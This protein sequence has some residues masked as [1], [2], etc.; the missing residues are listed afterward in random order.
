M[1]SNTLDEDE[2]TH[3][4]LLTGCFLLMFFAVCG[5]LRE[6]ELEYAAKMRQIELSILQ[7]QTLKAEAQ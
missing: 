3:R 1:K 4:W 6:Q 7:Y 5:M 2:I